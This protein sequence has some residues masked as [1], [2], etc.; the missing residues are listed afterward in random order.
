MFDNIE[1]FFWYDLETFGLNPAYDRIAQFAGQRTDTELNPIGDPVILY[2]RL[3][4]DYIPDPQAC[5]VTGI[6]PQEV[7]QKGIPESEFIEKINNIFSQKGTC[8][9]G[10]NSLRFDDEFIRNALYRNFL[11]PYE[12]EWKNGCSRWDILDLVRAAHDFRPQGINWPPHNDKGNPVFKLTEM[13]AAN[14]I[15][16][17]GAHDAMVDVNATIAVARLIKEKQ[18]KLFEHY[19]KLRNKVEVKN[20]LN[21]QDTPKPVLYTSGSFTNNNGCTTMIVPISPKPDQDNCILCFNL[22]RDP[23]ELFAADENNVYKA[24]GVLKLAINRSPF[25]APVNALSKED[26]D[27]LGINYT[28]CMTHYNQIM[29]ALPNLIVKLRNS[30][31]VVHDVLEDPDCAIYSKFFTDYDKTLFKMVRQAPPEQRIDLHFKFMDE[32]CPQMLWRHVCRNYPEVLDEENLEKWKNFAATR[33]LCPPGNPIN[34]IYFVERKID[35]KLQDSTLEE[36]QIK[37]LN[38]LKEYM[39]ALKRYVGIKES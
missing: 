7:K 16:Q 17:I 20:F 34:D 33:L 11:D 4:A 12:R 6:T 2:C 24:P 21:L 27:R 38:Q 9:C 36:K 15:E 13:T 19:L 25:L 28:V 31:N 29:H 35:E 10:F 8:V 1:S 32:R 37:T 39:I 26:Y 5:L 30:G 23:A 22:Q 14:N 3:S 18:P